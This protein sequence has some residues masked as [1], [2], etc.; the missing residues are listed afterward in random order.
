MS[1][2]EW[3]NFSKQLSSLGQQILDELIS[4]DD[5]SELT[6]SGQDFSVCAFEAA[7]T[8][9]EKIKE[10]DAGRCDKDTLISE[11]EMSLDAFASVETE[12]WLKPTSKRRYIEFRRALEDLPNMLEQGEPLRRNFYVYVH[13]DRNGNIFYVGK[14]TGKRAWS[15]DRDRIWHRYVKEK[16]GDQFEVEIVKNDLHEDEA[17]VLEQETMLKYGDCLLNF[18]KPG[19]VVT[20][21]GQ[22]HQ[23]G[24]FTIQSK[25][26]LTGGRTSEADLEMNERYWKLRNSNK[27]F[28][29][30]TKP[31]ESTDLQT[32]VTRYGE[33][34]QRMREYEEIGRRLNRPAGLRGE[35]EEVILSGD[36]GILDR[37]TLCLTKLN[38]GAEAVR[39]AERYFA[40][41]P[42]DRNSSLGQSVAKRIARIKAKG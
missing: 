17:L 7:E 38:R 22:V 40:D 29:L 30:D 39:E 21:E 34:L 13:K 37:L 35:Y 10:F 26:T 8:I 31:F 4:E 20:I 28:V 24:D 18:D 19:E 36:V 33:A 41:F 23:I 9:I 11:A 32:A 27:E 6:N 42:G 16:L 1:S 14:G 15:K 2:E 3:K 12:D 25:I 5:G